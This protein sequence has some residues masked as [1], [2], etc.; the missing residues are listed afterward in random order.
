MRQSLLAVILRSVQLAAGFLSI[1]G[2]PAP[3]VQV[4]A[5]LPRWIQNLPHLLPQSPSSHPSH[6]GVQVI[7]S[8]PLSE[9]PDEN[10]T[11]PPPLP[12]LK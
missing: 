7:Y 10:L 12:H 4:S 11:P 6:A 1:A 5:T 3:E 9:R 8:D 2:T